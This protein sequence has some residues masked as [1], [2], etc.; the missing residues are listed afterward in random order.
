[1]FNN[2]KQFFKRSI[3]PPPLKE[4]S[5]QDKVFQRVMDDL[6]KYPAQEWKRV[7]M[8]IDQWEHPNVPYIIRRESHRYMEPVDVPYD[9]LTANQQMRLA[10][11]WNKQQSNFDTRVEQE[12]FNKFLTNTGLN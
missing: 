6:R 3:V 4:P 9:F 5:L 7:R 11:L 12:Q 10:A 1:M 8:T 2:I